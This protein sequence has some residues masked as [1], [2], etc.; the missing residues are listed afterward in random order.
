MT[1]SYATITVGI[2]DDVLKEWRAKLDDP[3][4]NLQIAFTPCK[5]GCFKCKD[6]KSNKRHAKHKID[7][8]ASAKGSNGGVKHEDKRVMSVS[9]QANEDMIDNL[10]N[11]YLVPRFRDHAVTATV[12]R[13]KFTMKATDALKKS[14]FQQQLAEER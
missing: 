14:S 10:V 5:I 4:T 1:K 11:D 9:K 2:S 6:P 7:L 12:H 3:T 8:A 13:H